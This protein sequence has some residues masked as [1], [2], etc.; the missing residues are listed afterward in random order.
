MVIGAG[1]FLD[2]NGEIAFRRGNVISFGHE[3]AVDGSSGDLSCD[4]SFFGAVDDVP[5]HGVF[6]GRMRGV[7]ACRRVVCAGGRVGALRTTV[8][9]VLGLGMG[10]RVCR[11]LLGIS[12][13]WNWW[14]SKEWGSALLAWGF[15]LLN[16]VL[17]DVT[18]W[19]WMFV[20]LWAAPETEMAVARLLAPPGVEVWHPVNHP[21]V[22]REQASTNT[23]FTLSLMRSTQ[24]PAYS[25]KVS[26]KWPEPAMLEIFSLRGKQPVFGPVPLPSAE[27]DEPLVIDCLALQLELSVR[28]RFWGEKGSTDSVIVHVFP[29]ADPK[30]TLLRRCYLLTTL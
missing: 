23:V 30:R 26:A 3:R 10:M 15:A 7:V 17:A 13:V 24:A 16:M 9:L 25:W 11:W 8:G 20:A 12:G 4:T 5:A 21:R 1:I 6:V 18:L 22:T 2:I 28:K 19:G 27:T 14:V 29:R